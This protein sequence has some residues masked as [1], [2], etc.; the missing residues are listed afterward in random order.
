VIIRLVM[1]INQLKNILQ[2]YKF[3]TNILGFVFQSPEYIL[4]NYFKYIGGIPT[5][6]KTLDERYIEGFIRFVDYYDLKNGVEKDIIKCIINFTADVKLNDIT[7]TPV[8]KTL[9]TS[10]EENIGDINLIKT[11]EQYYSDNTLK[12]INENERIFKLLTLI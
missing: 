5:I 8:L 10:F 12:Y 9:R 11:S 3:N 2:F 1:E 7:Y 4:S 6:S